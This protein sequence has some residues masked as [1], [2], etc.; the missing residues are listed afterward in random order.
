M[1]VYVRRFEAWRGGSEFDLNEI[2]DEPSRR[3]SLFDTAI[4]IDEME[5]AN[6]NKNSASDEAAQEIILNNA[7]EELLKLDEYVEKEVSRFSTG[8]SL[9]SIEKDQNYTTVTVESS[10]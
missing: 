5:N 2:V 6:L 7:N 8:N 4:T 10:S 9:P 3:P 1:G